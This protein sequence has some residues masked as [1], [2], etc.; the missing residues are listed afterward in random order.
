MMQAMAMGG[1]T[2]QEGKLYLDAVCRDEL[3][4]I[5]R[6]RLITRMDAVVGD[7]AIDRRHDW[8]TGEAWNTIA[9]RGFNVQLTSGDIATLRAGGATKADVETLLTAIDMH[10]MNLNSPAGTA[11][12]LRSAKDVLNDH[13]GAEHSLNGPSSALAVLMLRQLMS[14][15]KAAA[16][17]AADAED[18]NNLEA[19]F[20]TP[21]VV[22]HPDNDPAQP[23]IPKP[24]SIP[25]TALSDSLQVAPSNKFTT[26]PKIMAVAGRVNASKNR[27]DC[28]VETQK[29]ILSTAALFTK[30]T[31]VV[32]ITGIE[33]MHLSY[34]KTTLEAQSA[35]SIALLE[36]YRAALTN[37]A[38]ALVDRG[39]LSGAEVGHFLPDLDLSGD[40]DNGAH[41][42]LVRRCATR[43][44]R[45]FATPPAPAARQF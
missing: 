16:W 9:A 8:A 25:A 31:G 30:V 28:T 15:A 26:D 14:S 1:L 5:R 19:V 33:Q 27:E 13:L 3:Q 41:S 22:A 29:Q 21:M 7:D 6:Q 34:F 2:P 32:D 35:R 10:V 20:A 18:G 45:Q 39:F 17:Q 12:M 24:A 38:D 42:S 36:P 40:A 11:K 43:T 4:R 44:F 37:L 23:V